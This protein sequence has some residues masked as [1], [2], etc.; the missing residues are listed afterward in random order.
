MANL[1]TRIRSATAQWLSRQPPGFAWELSLVVLALAVHVGHFLVYCLPQPWYIEDAAISFAYARNWVDGWGLVPYIGSD[2]V[3]GFS[4]PLWTFLIG[5]AYAIGVSPW[6]SSKVLGAA[7]GCL[8]QLCAWGIARR[9]LPEE[10]K[11]LAVLAPWLLAA[12]VQFTLWNAS[13]LENSLF[14]FCLAAGIYR[15]L[16]E[17]EEPHRYPLSALAFLGLTMTRPDGL[18]YAGIGLMARTMAAVAYRRPLALLSWLAAFLVPFAA[19]Q[20]WRMDYF[21]WE[22]PNT[23]YAKR[24]DFRPF[25]WNQLGWKQMREY[26]LRYGVVG[27]MPVIG[28]AVGGFQGWRKHALVALLLPVVFVLA[29]DGKPSVQGWQL[30]LL[31][32]T[33]PVV[34]A[35]FARSTRMARLY[36][37]LALVLLL[38][39]YGWIFAKVGLDANPFNATFAFPE[40]WKDAG[41]TELAKQWVKVRVYT[42][43]GTAALL[44]LMAFGRPGWLARGTLWCCYAFGLFYTILARGDWMKAYR[45]YSLTS[46]PQ[47]VLIT[48]GLAAIAALLPAGGRVLA[49][50]LKLGSLYAVVPALALMLANPWWA[51]QFV[52]KPETGPRD[53]HKRVEYM[54]WVQS[55]LGLDRVTLFDV[56]MG[57]HLWW[58]DWY[59]ADIAGLVDIATG[60][61]EYEKPFLQEYLFSE[62]RPEF[63]HVHG[64]WAG[65]IKISTHPEWKEEYLEIPGYPSGRR[66]LHVG[67]HIRRDLL[68]S[69]TPPETDARRVTFADGVRLAWWDVPSASVSPGSEL[70]VASRWKADKREGSL[71]VL[72]FLAREGALAWS[73]EVAPGLGWLEAKNWEQW[74]FVHGDWSVA[75]PD[76]LAAGDYQ[77]GM[78]VLDSKLGTVLPLVGEGALGAPMWG[79]DPLATP[80]PA[81]AAERPPAIFMTGEY[82][83]PTT[84]H[85]VEPAAAT[86]AAEARL[87][88]AKT[89]SAAGDCEGAEKGWADARRFVPLDRAWKSRSERGALDAIVGCFVARASAEADP[90]AAARILWDARFTD[91]RSALIAPV[92]VP[93]GAQLE[94]LGEAA[95]TERDWEG[96]Y[97]AF[98]GA[99]QADP[100]RAMARRRAED[101]RDRRLKIRDYDPKK[102]GLDPNEEPLPSLKPFPW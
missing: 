74:D 49:R 41:A 63:A 53:V 87:A 73:A 25:D 101:M 6:T 3:E 31:F 46:V 12:S 100:T 14:C 57:A 47:F 77:L 68:A 64:S 45:W 102:G 85:I 79:D 69:A 58:S 26:M 11:R 24:S 99:V 67:N 2:R 81:E 62:V 44:G 71:R 19:Y 48:L 83:L 43:A 72:L 4:N 7:F 32:A 65:T 75:I 17:A 84:V 94:L 78:V 97:V 61:H 1:P 22:W 88:E 40:S 95:F 76:T 70:F 15:L 42:L 51:Y 20:A 29:W 35:A 34:A 37:G 18:A 38:G 54:R 55:R 28:V 80:A 10:Q 59:I 60:H 13:G 52:M 86:A 16:V 91:P 82:L 30:A 21:A 92:G 90:V 36:L 9:A 8:A 5:G 33:P 23:W 96:A 39:L 98:R 89:A 93:L 50:R 27:A 56:D 66:A